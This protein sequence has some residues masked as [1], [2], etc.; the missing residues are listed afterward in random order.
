MTNSI[1]VHIHIYIYIY[2]LPMQYFGIF[3]CNNIS[4]LFYIIFI[5]NISSPSVFRKVCTSL[6]IITIFGITDSYACKQFM[7]TKHELP[8]VKKLNNT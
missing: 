7:R 3:I 8:I 5:N 2:L 4:I 6:F 1:Y